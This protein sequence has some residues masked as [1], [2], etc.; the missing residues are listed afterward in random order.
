[1]AGDR[2]DKAIDLVVPHVPQVCVRGDYFCGFDL[3][4]RQRPSEEPP[5]RAGITAGRDQ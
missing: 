2:I 1:M 5:G 4:R 3:Q